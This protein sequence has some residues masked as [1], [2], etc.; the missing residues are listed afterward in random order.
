MEVKMT[1]QTLGEFEETVRCPSCDREFESQKAMRIHHVQVH[2]ESLAQRN[3]RYRC[4]EC[5]REVDTERGLTNHV[6]KVHPETWNY[7]QDNG[8]VL[9]L[10]IE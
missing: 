4:L 3:D 10:M 9:E 6:A 8:M 2:G 7:I 1:Q 5:D